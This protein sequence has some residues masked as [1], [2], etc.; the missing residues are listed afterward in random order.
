V[1]PPLVAPGERPAEAERI[2]RDEVKNTVENLTILTDKLNP[3]ISNA[4]WNDKREAI[5]E[6]TVLLLNKHLVDTW[7]DE[8]DEETI[9]ERGSWLADR[10]SEVW[11]APDSPRWS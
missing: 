9:A 5:Q 7:S 10:A 2:E 11:F 1:I 8:W 3:S 6:H 4:A